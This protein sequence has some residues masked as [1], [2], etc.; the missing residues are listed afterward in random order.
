MEHTVLPIK[1]IKI[2]SVTIS[3]HATGTW[4]KYNKI[5]LP[6]EQKHCWGDWPVSGQN[7]LANHWNAAAAVQLPEACHGLKL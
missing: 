6:V 2:F 7:S 5:K 1:Y 4:Q 3:F